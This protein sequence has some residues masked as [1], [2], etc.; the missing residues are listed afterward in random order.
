MV[1]SSFS[2]NYIRFLGELLTIQLMHWIGMQGLMWGTRG[3]FLLVAAMVCYGCVG[4]CWPLEADVRSTYCSNTNNSLWQCFFYSYVDPIH[5]WHLTQH[6]KKEHLDL[7]TLV[8]SGFLCPVFTVHLL[9]CNWVVWAWET[10]LLVVLSSYMWCY[11][12][13]LHPFL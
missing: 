7:H 5:S 8:F 11:V 1:F 9:T 12:S 10:Q 6:L 3:P 2:Q 13:V 4:R